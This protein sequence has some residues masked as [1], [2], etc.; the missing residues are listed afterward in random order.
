MASFERVYAA[1]LRLRGIAPVSFDPDRRVSGA[2][3]GTV[4]DPD[5]GLFRNVAVFDFRRSL[6]DAHPHVQHRSPDQ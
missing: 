1:E 5:S 3:G 2:A 6:P 4:L